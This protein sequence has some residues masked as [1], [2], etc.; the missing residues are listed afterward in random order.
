MDIQKMLDW[1]KGQLGSTK[2]S[3]KCQAFVSYAYQAGGEKLVC[4]ESARAGKQTCMRSGTKNDR[5]PPAGAACYYTSSGSARRFGHVAIS[6]GNG[7]VYEAWTSGVYHHTFDYADDANGGYVGW[8]WHGVPSGQSGFDNVSAVSTGVSTAST[9]SEQTTVD[10]TE[11]VVKA[12]DG[13]QGKREA[14]EIR[15]ITSDDEMFLLVQNTAEDIYR[16]LL[17]GEVKVSR[18][19]S[20]SPSRLDFSYVDVDGIQIGQGNAV[21]FRYNGQ[22]VFYGYI[23]EQKRDS[24]REQVSVI[25]YDQLRYFKN[26]DSFVYSGKYSDLVKN[27]CNKY[28]LQTGT[29][30]ATA[31][32]LPQRV[33]EG[34]LFGICS[35]AAYETLLNKSE[36][37]VLYDDFGAICLRNINNMMLPIL[38]DKDAAGAWEWSESID[39][40]VYNR[41]TLYRDNDQTGERELYIANDTQKQSEWGILTLYEDAGDGLRAEGLREKAKALLNHY[42]HEKKTFQVSGCIGYPDVRGGSLI[43][44]ALDLGNGEKIQNLMLVEKVE[45]TFAENVHTMDLSLWGGEYSA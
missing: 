27:I 37:M 32:T 8:G 24:Q 20:G 44:V 28:G 23:F 36:S 30:D 45:H 2:W 21:A 19:R 6:D 17:A 31:Y 35:D 29:I 13:A 5:N 38:I 41:I 3:G 42:A 40:D 22:P 1:C 33:A 16:P 7:G 4:Y 14:S 9:A 18:E 26:E 11:V 12:T 43:L 15:T 10:I 25:A 34:D 39:S